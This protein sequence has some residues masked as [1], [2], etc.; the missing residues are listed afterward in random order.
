VRN[1]FDFRN[2]FLEVKKGCYFIGA[3]GGNGAVAGYFVALGQELAQR[4]NDVKIISHSAE[5]NERPSEHNLAS[6][7]WPSARPTKLSDGL[8]L[9]RLIRRHR[10]DCLLANFAA[11]NWMCLVGWL[12]RVRHRIAFYHTLRSQTRSDGP[13]GQERLK[14]VSTLRKRLV[15]KTATCVA[16][17]SQAAL[18]D[19]QNTFGV[20]ADKCWLWRYSMPDPQ[21]RF[22]LQPSAEREDLVLCAGRLFPSKGQDVLISALAILSGPAA[23]TKVE[24]LGTG[25]M[26]ESLRQMAEQKG[27][28]N[29]CRFVGVV[30]HDEVLARMSRAKITVVPSRNEAFGL[31]NIESMAVGTPVIAS[32][33]GGIPEIIHDGADG[34]LVPPD[35]PPAL[36]QKL[37]LLL[38]D[39]KLRERLSRNAREHFL[40]QYESSLVVR[41]QADWLEHFI[42]PISQGTSDDP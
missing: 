21:C 2:V 8:F 23:L 20:A 41:R 7:V 35:D 22:R 24:F 16:G 3:P 19:A 33:V 42:K 38:G 13:E 26:L 25:P 15:Y 12:C 5:A 40:A 4:G 34:Y 14:D 9:A 32:Q 18:L 6:L 37:T 28:A 30:S 39:A 1:P 31:V 27:V 36:A 17:I 10:P 11:V 29:R